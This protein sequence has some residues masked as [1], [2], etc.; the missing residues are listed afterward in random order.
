MNVPPGTWT[1]KRNV[2]PAKRAAAYRKQG[3]KAPGRRRGQPP[4]TRKGKRMIEPM[5]TAKMPIAATS[6][7][8]RLV[9]M[10]WRP[11]ARNAVSDVSAVMLFHC[12]IDVSHSALPDEAV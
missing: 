6:P 3:R 7:A 11:V 9:T 8:T 4:Q 5:I 10:L 2:A 1:G 12:R